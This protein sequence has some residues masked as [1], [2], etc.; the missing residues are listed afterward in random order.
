MTV[1]Q[2]RVR[3]NEFL[4]KDVVIKYSLGRN[5]YQKF[6]ATIKELYKNVFLVEIKESKIKNEIKSFSY[7][8]V[9]TKIIK[10]EY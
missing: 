4:G 10:I 3:L 2:I 9:I 7:S 8:D 1:E 6:N 5:K